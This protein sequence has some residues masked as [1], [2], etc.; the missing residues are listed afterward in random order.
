[1]PKK[2]R[3]HNPNLDGI[4]EGFPKEVTLQVGPKGQF[5]P[6]E[7]CGKKYTENVEK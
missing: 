3:G 5:H 6:G 7:N 4:T 2:P 1:M